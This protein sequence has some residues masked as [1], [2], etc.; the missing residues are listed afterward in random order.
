MGSMNVTNA[1]K[2]LYRIVE[3]VNETHEPIEI[4]GKNA[5]A[6]LVGEDDWR[7]ITETL[8][9]TY[10]PGMRESILEGMNTPVADLDEDPEW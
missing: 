10:I 1:R 9:L 3:E 7:S 8:F 2:N 4:T 6:V 5:S